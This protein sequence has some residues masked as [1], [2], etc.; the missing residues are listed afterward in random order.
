MW[1][2]L[3]SNIRALY[4]NTI[5]SRHVFVCLPVCPPF[6]ALPCQWFIPLCLVKPPVV[7]CESCAWCLLS[8]L[9]DVQL[10]LGVMCVCSSGERPFCCQFCPYRASQKGNLK[11]HVQS[12][13]HMPFDNSQYPDTRSSFQSQEEQ[14]AAKHPL[15]PQQQWPSDT[16][17]SGLNH[18]CHC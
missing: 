1:M 6:F 3:L 11:T 14:V 5:M 8:P 2:L 17:G 4:W 12:V 16:P 10:N 15:M 9:C 13:H 18:H 7:L